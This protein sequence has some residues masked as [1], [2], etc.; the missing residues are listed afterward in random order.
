[1][2]MRRLP[3]PRCFVKVVEG[4]EAW[5]GAVVSTT[6]TSCIVKR[7]GSGQ[8][9]GVSLEQVS[10]GLEKGHWVS[11]LPS[12]LPDARLRRGEVVGLRQIGDQ[13]LVLVE[14]EHDFTRQWLPHELLARTVDA[15]HAFVQPNPKPSSAEFLRLRLLGRGLYH[16]HLNTGGLAHLDIDPLPHQLHLVD[17]ILRDGNLNWLIADDVGLGKTIEV[18]LLI[19][20]LR[21]RPG[22]ERILVVTPAGLTRQWQEELSRRFGWDEAR[23]Y[24]DDFRGRDAVNWQKNNSLV[25]ASIDRLKQTEDSEV[26][27]AGPGW[28]LVVFDEAHRLTRKQDGTRITRSERFLL[29]E[30]LRRK[31]NSMLLLSATPHQGD[32]PRFHALLELLRP[33]WKDV[34]LRE[35]ERVP[36]LVRQCVFRNRKVDVTDAEGAF[37]FRGHTT[38]AVKVSADP[39]TERF[40]QLLNEY[41]LRAARAAARLKKQQATA[42]GLVI[43][44]FRK[45]AASSPAAIHRALTNR[46]TRATAHEEVDDERF[47]GEE[48]ERQVGSAID[49]FEGEVEVLSR[50]L[51]LSAEVLKHDRKLS[52]F[53]DK[54]VA[55]LV[56][57]DPTARL[58]IFT[59]YRATLESLEAALVR[60]FGRA[61]VVTIHGS[62]DHDTRIAA[63][64]AF[65][66]GDARFLVSTEAGGE[67]L[68]LHERCHRIVNYDMPWNP[69]RLVQRIGRV[70]RYG[71]KE[72]VQVYNIHAPHTVDAQIVQRMYDR[73]ET[74]A[75]DLAQLGSEFNPSMSLDIFGEL[76][77]FEGLGE[78]LS[79]REL[80]E[81]V[82]RTEERIQEAIEK[83]ERARDLHAELFTGA[84]HFSAS[85]EKR[86]RGISPAH[87]LSFAVGMVTTLGGSLRKSMYDGRL[88]EVDLGEGLRKRVGRR[89]SIIRLTADRVLYRRLI[90]NKEQCEFLDIEKPLFKH[91]AETALAPDFGRDA[92]A[93]PLP[94]LQGFFA[95]LLRWQQTS[96]KIPREELVVYGL[97]QAGK[98]EEGPA[99]VVEW[100]LHPATDGSWPAELPSA[101]KSLLLK[102][103]QR[104]EE[105]MG[106]GADL[107]WFP[108]QWQL[109]GAVRSSA[110]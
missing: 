88:A 15:K 59:E 50:L 43:I 90:K 70:Y 81:G 39:L 98:L 105:E 82:K 66:E 18:G 2:A 94:G 53:M 60:R 58:L 44:A 34:L 45:L 83:A 110:Q 80:G 92:A 79:E 6:E 55:P 30:G 77:A 47:E 16:W 4:A 17:S 46:L 56:Q 64:E 27:M 54:L 72:V 108:V 67:G 75:G 99:A 62:L 71:Q 9:V 87:V 91:L 61:A 57:H 11:F 22:F 107:R 78:V 84:Q 32:S 73:L 35:Q 25:I 68:N 103:L 20:A 28:D 24:G 51:D 106:M 69:M 12:D 31:T 49:L 101:R 42:I 89:G 40:D 14:F 1:L 85:S 93:T 52:E 86:L 109:V 74:I 13:E 29:A 48:V 3:V 33:E 10:S 41:L 26:L 76:A 65:T 104:A 36:D 97:D 8:E 100:L 96:A 37:I 5:E 63:A 95:F 21:Q 102:A 23:I 38:K 19:S 7:V